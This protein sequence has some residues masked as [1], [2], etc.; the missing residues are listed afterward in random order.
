MV[1]IR[2]PSQKTGILTGVQKVHLL[3][4]DRPKRGL[5]NMDPPDR[6]STAAITIVV[7][8]VVVVAAASVRDFLII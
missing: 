6:I 4:M 1:T 7:S 5:L 3:N 8:V 2:S